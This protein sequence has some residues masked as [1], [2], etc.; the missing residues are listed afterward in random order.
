MLY[1][2]RLARDKM[3]FVR[4][5]REQDVRRDAQRRETL[6]AAR[7]EVY[8][9]PLRG[10]ARRAARRPTAKPR[11]SFVLRVSYSRIGALITTTFFTSSTSNVPSEFLFQ[12][13]LYKRCSR[14]NNNNNN[15]ELWSQPLDTKRPKADV[16][17]LLH[18]RTRGNICSST[19]RALSY[20][21]FW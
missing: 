13:Q 4:E 18:D 16:S 8:P 9:W 3:W 10:S 17:W 1:F 2:G 7:A 19:T 20:Y 15:D 12:G 11:R 6:A 14:A 21:Y 5:I